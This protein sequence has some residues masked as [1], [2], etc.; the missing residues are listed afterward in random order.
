MVLV[1]VGVGVE[2]GV[3][4]VLCDVMFLVRFFFTIGCLV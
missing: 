3:L 2:V 1:E 4:E